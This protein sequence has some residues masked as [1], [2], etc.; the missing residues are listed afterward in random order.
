MALRTRL[1]VLVAGVVVTP[2]STGRW[3]G[4]TYPHSSDQYPTNRYNL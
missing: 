3:Q 4:T 1:P 2:L